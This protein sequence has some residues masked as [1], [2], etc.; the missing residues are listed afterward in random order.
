MSSYVLFA[1]TVAIVG[2]ASSAVA[3]Q[4]PKLSVGAA[5]GKYLLQIGGGNDCHTPGHTISGGKVDL[6]VTLSSGIGLGVSVA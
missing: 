1:A 6:L 3:Q 5:R 2:L 4:A